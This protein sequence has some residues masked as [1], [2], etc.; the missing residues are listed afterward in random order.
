MNTA[1]SLREKAAHYRRLAEGIL[2][3]TDPTRLRLLERAVECER[4]AAAMEAEEGERQSDRPS[5]HS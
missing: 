1:E 5:K 4:K 3:T 2:R